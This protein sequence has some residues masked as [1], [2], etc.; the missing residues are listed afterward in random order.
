MPR[1]YAHRGGAG[2]FV[3]NS[4]RAFEFALESGCDGAE[5]DVHLTKDGEVIVHHN[6]RLNHRYTR[7]Q[8]GCWISKK[9]EIDFEQLS[10]PEINKYTIGEPN[11]QTHDSKTWPYLQALAHQR[12]PTLRQLIEAIKSKS[13]S[14]E[15]VI[16]IKSD[17]FNPE[18]AYA[19]LLVDRVVQIICEE[20][21]TAQTVLC[22]FDWRTLLYAQSRISSIP[23]WFTTHPFSWLHSD[24]VPPED[25]PPDPDYLRRLRKALSDNKAHWYAG[26]KVDI[27]HNFP[28]VIKK[29]GGDAW[30]CY[31]TDASATNLKNAHENGLELAVWSVNLRKSAALKRLENVD[32]VCVDYPLDWL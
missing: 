11:P 10:V 30:F 12:I 23:I 18:Y 27:P 25:I 13:T 9:D 3:E 20:D 32:A 19:K 1:I 5:C 26:L 8:D 6:P 21:F 17:I 31:H 22:S 15:L 24:A 4:L 14:F 28:Q 2:Y 7:K 29:A 16:E